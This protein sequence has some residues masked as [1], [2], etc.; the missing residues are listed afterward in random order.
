MRKI[1]K[2]QEDVINKWI[3]KAEKTSFKASQLI[4]LDEKL[5]SILNSVENE[6]P[7]SYFPRLLK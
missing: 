6:K 2:L 7:L 1:N 5:N 3:E 4:E